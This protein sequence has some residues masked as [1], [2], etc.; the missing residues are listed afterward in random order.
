MPRE[1]QLSMGRMD[2]VFC[3]DDDTLFCIEKDDES[4][5]IK[6]G[7]HYYFSQTHGDNE[8]PVYIRSTDKQ[9]QHQQVILDVNKLAKNYDYFAYLFGT[10]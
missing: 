3:G 7:S 4:V 6:K 1:Y 2:K 8:Y 5:P 9:G 10:M